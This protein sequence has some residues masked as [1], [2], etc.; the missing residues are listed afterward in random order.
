[1]NNLGYFAFLMPIVLFYQQSKNILLKIFSIFWKT[2]LV[3][4]IL[5]QVAYLELYNNSFILNFNNYDLIRSNIYSLKYNRNLLAYFKLYTFEIFLYKWYIPLFVSG[6]SYLNNR[7]L[8]IQYLSFTFNFDKFIDEIVRRY[9]YEE[10]LKHDNLEKKFNRFQ[11]IEIRGRSIKNKIDDN[12]LP[13]AASIQKEDSF[14]EEKVMMAHTY[15]PFLSIT[16][17][18]E[19]MVFLKHNEVLWSSP[20][21]II[22]NKY[23]FTD[24]G[25][26]VLNQVKKW[27]CAEEWYYERNI[28][29]KRGMLL[30]GS[31][32]QGKSALILEIAKKLGLTIYSF[33]LSLMDNEEFSRNLNNLCPSLD[34]V[35]FED[36]DNIWNGRENITKTNNF[37]GL[38][39][40]CFI[41]KL[42]GINSVKNKFIFITTNHIENVDTALLRKGRIDEIITLQ[43]LNS[44]EKSNMANLILDGINKQIIDK[45]LIDGQND[46]TAEFENR[47]IQTA[48]DNFWNK[49]D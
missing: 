35:L 20:D 49:K 10:C 22:K 15:L 34:I 36:I 3:P 31:P 16:K 33:D 29:H 40:D 9:Y 26:Y 23:Q 43:P 45:I 8:K 13:P 2:K 1:M 18:I 37:G 41:N 30:N 38:T 4:D 21:V 24:Q 27:I 17:K 19:S 48:L 5:D 7:S 25:K 6:Y 11:I 14:P 42:S 32:G 44:I 28:V 46:S 39:F 47:C 12:Y